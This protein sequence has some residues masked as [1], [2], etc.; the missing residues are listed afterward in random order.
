M[1]KIMKIKAKVFLSVFVSL[2]LLSSVFVLAGK[3][4]FSTA[5][6]VPSNGNAV[7]SI[8]ENAVEVSQGVFDLGLGSDEGRLVQGYAFVHYKNSVNSEKPAG[9]G[10]GKN[11]ASACYGYIANGAKWRNLESWTINPANSRGLDEAN[12]FSNL[13]LDIVKWEDAADG[14][15]D[16]NSLNILGTGN[17][18][19]NTLVADTS[20][21]D[22][23]NEVYFADV[24][25]SDAIA[26]TIV[27][28]TIGSPRF[29][30]IVEWDQ[31]YDDVDFDWS[32]EASGVAGK[33]DIENIVTH[34]L[35]HTFGMGDLYDSNCANETMYGYASE[36]ETNKRTLESGDIE[37]VSKLY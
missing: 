23:V 21:T 4:D 25:N 24:S 20:S 11:G 2:V 14:V 10:G 9:V 31:V 12:V 19:S 6:V 5:D 7:V 36:A 13:D 34:E 26:V 29:K 22:G 18:T 16:G 27:W 1:V 3:P 33:M 15:I 30:Q 17:S 37:G 28:Y 35:G 8:P 32:L